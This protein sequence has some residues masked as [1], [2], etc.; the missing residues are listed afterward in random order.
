VLE[1]WVD[2]RVR[3][4]VAFAVLGDFNR[5]LERDARLGAGP[6]EAA[7]LGFFNALSDNQPPGAV[8]L[9]ATEGAPYLRCTRSEA[10]TL[11]IDDVLVSQ[12][13][14]QRARSLRMVR[15]PFAPEDEALQISDHC[16]LGVTLEGLRP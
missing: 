14:A 11:Y 13:L 16:P 2:A 15:Q 6:D 3:E 4:G 1:R 12:K 10:H 7:P 9:R 8:L 5:H